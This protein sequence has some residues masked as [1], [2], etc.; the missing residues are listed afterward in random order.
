MRVELAF[1]DGDN[2]LCR[3]RIICGPSEITDRFPEE[4]GDLMFAVTHVFEEPACPLVIVCSRSGTHLYRTAL[5][6]GV[7][8]S[9]DWESIEL[10]E[11]HTLAFRCTLDSQHDA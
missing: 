9:E 4:G 7:H 1:F 8:T 5:R 3:G 10:G 11:A 2:L 6:M